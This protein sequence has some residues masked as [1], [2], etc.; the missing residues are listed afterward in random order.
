MIT[1]NLSN[2]Y[3][4]KNKKYKLLPNGKR[5]YFFYRSGLSIPFVA[6]VLLNEKE[7]VPNYLK[8]QNKNI[9]VKKEHHF[10]H[11]LRQ[12]IMS[13]SQWWNFESDNRYQK[14]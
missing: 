14:P 4:F 6:N 8:T 1:A 10:S 12:P 2:D 9:V 5:V 11:L 13:M 7:S 3:N